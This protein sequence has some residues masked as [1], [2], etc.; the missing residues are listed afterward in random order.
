M[1]SDNDKKNI[2]PMCPVELT[3]SLIGSKWKVLIVRELIDGSKRFGEIKKSLNDIS[4]KVLTTHLREMEQSGLLT[5]KIY[6]EVPPRVEYTLTDIG[7]SLKPIFNTL[8]VWGIDYYEK[9]N[10]IRNNETNLENT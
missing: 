8:A 2:M 1:V 6:A 10:K 9:I 4:Q 5:R 7:Y 3:L